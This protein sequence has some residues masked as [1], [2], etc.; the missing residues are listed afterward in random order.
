MELLRS[1]P[2]LE[3]SLNLLKKTL[4]AYPTFYFI[5]VIVIKFSVKREK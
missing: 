5:L 1:N 2:K 4:I 3:V